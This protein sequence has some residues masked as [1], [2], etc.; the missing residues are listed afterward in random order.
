LKFLVAYF[1][2]EIQISKSLPTGRQPKQIQISK[3]LPS[4]KRLR[5]GG[6]MSNE[7]Q[8]TECQNIFLFDNNP[9]GIRFP[10]WSF[11]LI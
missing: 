3:S 9:K 1:K 4:P 11:D 8:V 6:Q 2:F 7:A 5:A 10:L